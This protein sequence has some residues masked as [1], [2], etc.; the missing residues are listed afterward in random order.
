MTARE[1]TL[2]LPH[3]AGPLVRGFED[4]AK[5]SGM[6]LQVNR[7][8]GRFIMKVICPDIDVKMIIKE[9]EK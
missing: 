2:Q 1:V 6:K 8:N 9:I 5:R 7:R 3:L 4:W